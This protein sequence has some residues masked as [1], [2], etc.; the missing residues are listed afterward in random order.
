[1]VLVRLLGGGS[2]VVVTPAGWRQGCL[3]QVARQLIQEYWHYL[4][5]T[6]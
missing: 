5:P 4:S 1:M 3:S 6:E 2:V